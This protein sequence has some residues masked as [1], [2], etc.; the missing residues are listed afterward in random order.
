MTRGAPSPDLTWLIEALWRKDARVARGSGGRD[1]SGESYLVVPSSHRPRFLLPAERR[2]AAGSLRTFN[3]LRPP[4]TRAARSA[5]AAAIHLGL[6]S[7][8]AR[9]RV[10]VDPRGSFL[11]EL[12]RVLGR[13]EVLCA[14]GLAPRGPN[15]KPVLQVFSPEGD[16]I[17]FVKVGW[18][19]T[20]RRRVEREATGLSAASAAQGPLRVPDLLHAG[21]WGHLH[22]S[23]TAPLPREVRRFTG[24][25]QPLDEGRALWS[26]GGTAVDLASSPYFERLRGR[27]E[28]L[29]EGPRRSTV[30]AL[31]DRTAHRFGDVS[32]AVGACHGD[33]VPWNMARLGDRVYVFDWEHWRDDAPVGFDVLHWHFQIPF[34]R[35][36]RPVP[37]AWD[38]A[39]RTARPD[40]VAAGLDETGI[41]ALS[42]VYL[43]ELTLRAA[44]SLAAGGMRNERWETAIDPLLDETADGDAR[45][46]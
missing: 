5:V 10:V 30:L 19:E 46:R 28:G 39:R 7:L 36:R 17:A 3:R 45:P 38:A 24:D 40:L 35:D 42:P 32:L 1:Q 25:R 43:A 20:T 9:D 11:G 44:E 33:W 14:I 29:P 22:L 16:P 15:R 26:V 6:Q 41:A 31:L 2:P 13:E 21:P 27:A 12:R 34:I 37:Q 8:V 4:A 23:V 18:N